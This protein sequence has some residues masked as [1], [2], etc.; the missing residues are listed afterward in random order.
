MSQYGDFANFL[1]D[2]S[3]R[4]YPCHWKDLNPPGNTPDATG[5]THFGV[6]VC[7]SPAFLCPGLP[8]KI[9]GW[10]VCFKGPIMLIICG[11]YSMLSVVSSPK[12]DDGSCAKMTVFP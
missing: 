1:N 12:K 9:E 4:F 6:R 5:N 8:Q 7:I 2:K 10:Q 11:R 3:G